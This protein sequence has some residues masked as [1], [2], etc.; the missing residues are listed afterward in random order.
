MELYT[1]GIDKKYLKDYVNYMKY[2]EE[3]SVAK[4]KE[5]IKELGLGEIDEFGNTKKSK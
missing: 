3:Q 4:C 2:I 1:A 5:I